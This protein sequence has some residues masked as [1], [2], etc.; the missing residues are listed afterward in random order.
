MRQGHI[1]LSRCGD[2]FLDLSYPEHKNQYSGFDLVD[3][4]DAERYH[5]NVNAG[6]HIG[7]GADFEPWLVQEFSWL[8]E[9]EFA[10]NRL[11]AGDILPSHCDRYGS[12]RT[13][14]PAP[15]ESLTRVIVFLQ[16]WQPGHLLQIDHTLLAH[17]HQGD[18]AAWTGHTPHLAA[19]LGHTDRY[20]LQ[21]TGILR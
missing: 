11:R 17:W 16:D 5:N 20:T 18:W 13:R 12:Y 1:D 15:I 21:I 10:V 4:Q 9:M 7:L 19:N 8:T 14:H 6:I 2:W 3:A